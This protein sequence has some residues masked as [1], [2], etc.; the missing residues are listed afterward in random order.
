MNIKPGDIIVV[1]NRDG[2]FL[3]SAIRFFTNS[4]SHTAIGFFDMSRD[5]F[6]VQT[7]FEANLTTGITDWQK[8]FSD[9][10]CDLRIYRWTKELGIE[11]ICWKL[12]DDYNGNIY[13][14]SQLVYFIWRWVVEK[15]HLPYRWAKKNPFPNKEICTEIIYVAFAKLENDTV[16]AALVQLN[17]DQNTV[18]PGDIIEICEMLVSV[19]LL[20]R[21]Y[22]REQ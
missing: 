21:I 12:F 8:T 7:I 22:N 14:A 4:W 3:S 15:L 17:R 20:R 16:N 1:N 2:N 5:P 6:P 11:K 9:M 13:G 19:G 10:H 18:H